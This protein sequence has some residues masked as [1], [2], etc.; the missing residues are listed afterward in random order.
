VAIIFSDDCGARDQVA[1]GFSEA[2]ANHFLLAN[3]LASVAGGFSHG[4]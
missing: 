4:R 2:D 3:T 1:A